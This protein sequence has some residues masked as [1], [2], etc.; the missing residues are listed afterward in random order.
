[1]YI[2]N[3][4]T[5]TVLSSSEIS[6]SN[7]KK[8]HFQLTTFTSF[9]EILDSIT[10]DILNQFSSFRLFAIRNEIESNNC[11]CLYG[12]KESFNEEVRQ[13]I[14]QG[15]RVSIGARDYSN[16]RSDFYGLSFKQRS[17]VCLYKVY[18]SSKGAVVYNRDTAVHIHLLRQADS[19]A[20][21]CPS[22]NY[23]FS[24]L[25]RGVIENRHLLA[26]MK[27]TP[28]F[29]FEVD[30]VITWVDGD[31][32]SWIKS[33]DC[34]ANA[35]VKAP[36]SSMSRSRYQ[37]RDEIKY[38]IRSILMY[39]PW[40]RNIYLVTD[41]QI[42]E[43]FHP[44]NK[45]RIIDHTDIFIDKG[46][47]PVFNSHAIEANLHRITGLAEN[48]LYFND[49]FLL[50]K[51][52]SKS[53][54]FT[55]FGRQSKF[56][57]SNIAFIPIEDQN[58]LLPVDLAARNNADI[59]ESLTKF[60]PLRK[61]QHTPIALKK[62]TLEKLESIAPEIFTHTSLSRFRAFSDYSIVSALAHHYGYYL[63]TAQPG[64]IKYTYID[65]GDESARMRIERLFH[66]DQGYSCICINDVDHTD[67]LDLVYLGEVLNSIYCQKSIAEA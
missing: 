5:I 29:D 35:V 59:I 1:M 22:N 16:T 67:D 50:R 2:E 15:F 11:F 46:V 66:N 48:F 4:N 25:G 42:P 23:C 49:D 27:Q 31:D 32:P 40:V 19:G 28:E 61:F 39:A 17:P 18:C 56:F 3:T 54:F 60:R 44:N 43:W 64:E 13:L 63:G 7:R 41:N 65:L 12:D 6:D 9:L 62:S 58:G 34:Y 51:P 45:V 20:L 26:M 8:V 53:S 10:Q 14:Y 55:A 38:S 37:S 52:V 33:K 57:Y 24:T 21:T 47:L 30:V 36:A